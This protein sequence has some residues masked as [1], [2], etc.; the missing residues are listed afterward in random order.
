MKT[1]G[2]Y[3]LTIGIRDVPKEGKKDSFLQSPEQTTPKD[4]QKKDLINSP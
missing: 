3:D 1:K 2:F 4:G